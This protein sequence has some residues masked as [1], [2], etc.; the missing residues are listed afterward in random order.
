MI[1]RTQLAIAFSTILGT[2]VPPCPDDGLARS[3]DFERFGRLFSTDS[4]R[5]IRD[6]KKKIVFSKAATYKHSKIYTSGNPCLI[7]LYHLIG[8]TDRAVVKQRSK[9]QGRGFRAKCGKAKA[10][11]KESVA[12]FLEAVIPCPRGMTPQHTWLGLPAV[13]V[14]GFPPCLCQPRGTQGTVL[15]FLLCL[16]GCPSS[17]WA[18]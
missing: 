14:L 2:L 6:Q 5:R 11:F 12:I 10:R 17:L 1:K 16:A 8:Q 9:Y 7:G 3:H 18:A 15:K 13:T 4:M